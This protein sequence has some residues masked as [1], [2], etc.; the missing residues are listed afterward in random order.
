M[1]LL[2]LWKESDGVALCICRQLP[3]RIGVDDRAPSSDGAIR[4]HQNPE[5]AHTVPQRLEGKFM[6]RLARALQAVH[7]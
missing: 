5:R 2:G 4:Q 3:T 1:H 7:F 6:K